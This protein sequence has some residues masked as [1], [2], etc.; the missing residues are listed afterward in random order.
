[1]DYHF[2]Q[3]F[4]KCQCAAFLTKDCRGLKT[5]HVT[6]IFC[7]LQRDTVWD[8]VVWRYECICFLGFFMLR[9]PHKGKSHVHNKTTVKTVPLSYSPKVHMLILH[10]YLIYDKYMVCCCVR[11][12]LPY[13][14]FSIFILFTLDSVFYFISCY[15]VS[16]CCC[17]KFK[18]RQWE[19]LKVDLILFHRTKTHKVLGKKN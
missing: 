17:V 5:A 15:D 16:L 2:S 3:V 10:K 6:I 4:L 9:L 12:L 11:C 14:F 1:M 18:F 19:S 13:I 7:Y 8:N